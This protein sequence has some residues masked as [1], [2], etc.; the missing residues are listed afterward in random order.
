[1]MKI[2][3]CGAN[4]RCLGIVA[5][6]FNIGNGDFE[7]TVFLDNDKLKQGSRVKAGY[8]YIDGK[9]VFLNI[10]ST[11][12]DS[13]DNVCA[14]EWDYILIVATA[15]EDI[16][17]QLVSHG[18]EENCIIYYKKFIESA[19]SSIPYLGFAGNSFDD[20]LD[21]KHISGKEFYDHIKDIYNV[22]RIITKNT[23]RLKILEGLLNAIKGVINNEVVQVLGVSMP[24]DVFAKS[25][26]LFVYEMAD[27]LFD[28]CYE[29]MDNMEYTEGPYELGNIKIEDSSTVLDIGAN[30]GLFTALAA[31]KNPNGQ[32]YAFEP[33][34]ETRDVLKKVQEL[35]N[36]VTIVPFGIADKEEKY[37]VDISDYD[38]NPGAVSIMNPCMTNKSEELHVISLDEYVKRENIEKIDYIKADIEGAERLLL[39]GAKNVLKKM[40]PRLV[41]CTYHYNEDPQLLSFLIKNANEN[42]IIEYAYG[43]LYAEVR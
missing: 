33:V 19:V 24:P 1:M 40:A 34:S 36:N 4:P 9:K 8:Y 20:L 13:A 32:I 41:I 22:G 10:P 16:S 17:K 14:Y 27:I 7:I 6:D 43:K 28:N 31:T 35:Y 30:F 12:I 18:V 26:S 15:F 5:R 25:P 39:L 3:V 38:N 37:N 29:E 42:Y 21:M 11:I 23:Y 2:A